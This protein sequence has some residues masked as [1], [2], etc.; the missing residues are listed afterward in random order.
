MNIPHFSVY[1]KSDC[2][3][4]FSKLEKLNDNLEND[5]LRVISWKQGATREYLTGIYD[6][7]NMQGENNDCVLYGK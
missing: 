6:G 5:L 1:R 3:V 4:L 7:L 2:S